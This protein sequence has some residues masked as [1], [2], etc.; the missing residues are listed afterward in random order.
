MTIP[1]LGQ[2]INPSKSRLT[3]MRL[4]ADPLKEDEMLLY[5]PVRGILVDKII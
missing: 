2:P 1:S 4:K 5:F 3:V